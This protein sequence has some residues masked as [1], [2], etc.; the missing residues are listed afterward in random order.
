MDG[1]LFFSCTIGVCFNVV[2]VFYLWNGA[3]GE[4]GGGWVHSVK[5][6]CVFTICMLL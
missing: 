1:W 3:Q 6:E 2:V 4:G 5:N